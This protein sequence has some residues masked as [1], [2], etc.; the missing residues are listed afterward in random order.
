MGQ[1]K[2][3][4]GKSIWILIKDDVVGKA[5]GIE[6]EASRVPL[7]TFNSTNDIL[8]CRSVSFFSGPLTLLTFQ[9]NI[10]EEKVNIVINS[11]DGCIVLKDV[12][13][14]RDFP[15]EGL[16][17]GFSNERAATF[18]AREME[19]KEGLWSSYLSI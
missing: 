3:E 14:S 17:T 6:L 18:I 5:S 8:E 16:E 9:E 19:C 13:I 15:N 2:K 10:F 1:R 12:T 4:L 7:P 11:Q